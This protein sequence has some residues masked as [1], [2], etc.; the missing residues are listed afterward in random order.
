MNA[1]GSYYGIAK[2]VTLANMKVK[3]IF[4]KEGVHKF[5]V[6]NLSRIAEM[7]IQSTEDNELLEIVASEI[8]ANIST[9]SGLDQFLSLDI[10]TVEFSNKVVSSCA[11]EIRVLRWKLKESKKENSIQ[12]KITCM[13]KSLE[14]LRNNDCCRNSSCEAKFE[15]YIEPGSD[16]LRCARCRCR[17]YSV[18]DS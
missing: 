9:P 12:L 18:R 10:C 6:G 1:I 3:C 2:L 15:C 13:E 17:H 11:Q 4:Q 8:A 16:L 14:A 7:A 5:W